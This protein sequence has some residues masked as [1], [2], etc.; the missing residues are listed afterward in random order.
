MPIK[1]RRHR[2]N[3][4]TRR[5]RKTLARRYKKNHMGGGRIINNEND[6]K[7]SWEQKSPLVTSWYGDAGE[8]TT[9]RVNRGKGGAESFEQLRESMK[10]YLNALAEKNKN[11]E[12]HLYKDAEIREEFN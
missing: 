5:N 6:L 2:K 8:G 12:H 9:A 7:E 1:S 11:P 4:I 10:F 3:K